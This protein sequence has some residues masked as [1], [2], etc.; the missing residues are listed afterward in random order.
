MGESTISMAIFNSYVK[1]P[2]GIY[3]YMEYPHLYTDCRIISH[4]LSGMHIQVLGNALLGCF[5]YGYRLVIKHGQLENPIHIEM[6][7]FFDYVYALY[8]EHF[9]VEVGWFG[10]PSHTQS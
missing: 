2:E 1:L 9:E 3:D 5:F 4:L 6:S 10:L 7:C 8:V